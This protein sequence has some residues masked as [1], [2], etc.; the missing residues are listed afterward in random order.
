MHYGRTGAAPTSHASMCRA[1]IPGPR[2]SASVGPYVAESSFLPEIRLSS[3]AARMHPNSRTRPGGEAGEH[4][5]SHETDVDQCHPAGR[6]A[7]GDGEGQYLI[8]L[9]IEVASHSQKKASIYKGKVTRVSRA[10]R[11]RSS[12]TAPNARFSAPE[13]GGAGARSVGRRCF[14]RR[15]AKRAERARGGPGVPGQ[16]DKE[17]RGSKGAA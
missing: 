17:E 4:R 3:G 15:T 11:R 5:G 7:G 10:W 6:A 1:I 9:D 2:R 16:V 8:D 14:R 12:T 13:G